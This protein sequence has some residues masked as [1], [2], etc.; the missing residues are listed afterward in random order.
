MNKAEELSGVVSYAINTD[1][2]GVVMLPT[3]D[4]KEIAAELRRLSAENAELRARL[5]AI[6]STEPVAWDV[7]VAEV[8]NGYLVDSLDDAQL[9]DDMTNHDAVATPL[10]P[11]PE[12]S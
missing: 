7:Y 9:I 10:I 8:D 5:D 12:K 4:A 2:Y 11:L 3:S 1:V 6:Y